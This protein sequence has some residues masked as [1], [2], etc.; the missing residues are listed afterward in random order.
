LC[1]IGENGHAKTTLADAAELW[2]TGDLAAFHREGCS[3]EAAIHLDASAASV[4]IAGKGF[5]PLR[6]TLTSAGAGDLESLG[7]DAGVQLGGDPTPILRHMTIARFMGQT[8]GEKKK[9]LLELLVLGGLSGLREPLKTSCSRAKRDADDARRR[10]AGERAAV[11]SQLADEELVAYAEQ[12]RLRAGIAQPIR[13]PGDILALPLSGPPAVVAD[14]AGPVD[15]LVAALATL[16]EDP[17]PRWNREVADEAAVRADGTAA[18]LK[19]AQ[20]VVA[21]TDRSCPVCEQPIV[22]AELAESLAERAATL[23]VIRARLSEAGDELDV[24]DA[25]LGVVADAISD[26]RRNAPPAG[27]PDEL[28]ER[29]DGPAG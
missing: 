24:L 23:E 25:Q 11:K 28:A 22:G 9:A 29:L 12:R 18:L 26:V 5:S 10:V 20:R 27:W 8:A 7:P 17:A 4:E 16:V 13:K 14:R 3:L 19:A 21:P 2:S 6:R 15:R 1:L